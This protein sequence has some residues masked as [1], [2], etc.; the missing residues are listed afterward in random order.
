MSIIIK[1]SVHQLVDFL[2]R[3]GDIDDRIFNSDTME[4]GSK[5]HRNFQRKQNENYLSEV[6]LKT[7]IKTGIY[8]VILHG[9]ADGVILDKIVTIDEIKS[10]NSTLS[11]F[12]DI[13]EEW[14]L[15][16]AECYAYMY[17][18]IH[19]LDEINIRLTYL[20][21]NNRKQLFKYFEYK[22]D[23]LEIKIFTLISRYIDFYEIINDKKKAKEKSVKT[24]VFPF[25]LRKG[26][27]EIIKKSEEAIINRECSFIEA[28]TGLGK[29]ISVIFGALKGSIKSKTDKLFF[30]CAKHSGFKSANDCLEKLRDN[31]LRILSCEIIAKEKMCACKNHGC[32]PECKPDVCPFARDY[33]TKLSEI[34]S[35]IILENDNFSSERIKQIA[36]ENSMCPFELSL[37]ISLYCDFIIC[38]YNYVFN[39]ISY[40]KRF[41]DELDYKYSKF[42][43][44]DEA[45]NLVDRS[46][47]M[48]STSLSYRNYLA[49]KR[50]YSKIKTKAFK[51][52]MNKLDEDFELFNQF[53]ADENNLLLETIDEKFISHL[54]QFKTALKNY[55]QKHPKFKIKWS[56]EFS[57]EVHK[58]LT[59]YD[60]IDD[61]YRIYFNRDTADNFN[62]VFKCIDASRYLKDRVDNCE[63]TVLFSGTLTPINYYKKMILGSE[64]YDSIE[65]ISPFERNNLKVLVNSKIST[66]YKDRQ[67]TLGLVIKNINDFIT[68][69]NG[70]YIVYVPS[71]EYL[72]L[73]KVRYKNNDINIIYQNETMNNDEKINFLNQ[74]MENPVKTT[75]GVCVLG[76]SFGEGIDLVSDRLIGV[77][78]V[79][80]GL[81]SVNFENNLIKDYYSN[82]GLDG[83]TF[84]YVN[85]GINKVMQAVGRLI[86]S[87]ND[88][89]VALLIDERYCYK[90]YSFLFNTNWQNYKFIKSSYELQK[91]LNSFYKE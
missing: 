64:E 47:D 9:R 89:G 53:Q 81:P 80:V 59:I 77:V 16:Q 17:A 25:S 8:E 48:F 34:F 28:S 62:I 78:I 30:L 14:H 86:R 83:Y 15:G 35:K 85:P 42:L 91:E 88:R 3:K 22:F 65:L 74:F 2:L 11:E 4:E 39:P 79:G 69:K 29:T 68:Y 70:N 37:D 1:L 38:D 71:F 21:Q 76:G 24:L 52:V 27:S 31:G 5:I 60:F 32:L 49:A 66:K 45:H 7:S 40:L 41:F 73:L 44:I 19:N 56:K 57:L 26:Q 46:R 10:T 72:R 12:N 84:A 87:E 6:D 82:N 20:S 90:T 61:N 51:D 23:D 18:K 33:Y 55:Q 50:D 58:F 54:N 75:L 43:M 36:L 13:N 63:G 67:N